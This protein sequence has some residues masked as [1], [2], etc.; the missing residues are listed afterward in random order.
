MGVKREGSSA[1]GAGGCQCETGVIGYGSD[2]KEVIGTG[3]F[4]SAGGSQVVGDGLGGGGAGV[5]ARGCFTT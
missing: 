3:A 2:G 1:V 4:G 5:D